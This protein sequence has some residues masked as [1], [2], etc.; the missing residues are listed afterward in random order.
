MLLGGPLSWATVSHGAMLGPHRRDHH[1]R[2]ITGGEQVTWR[3]A[4]AER[5][6]RECRVRAETRHWIDSCSEWR[7]VITIMMTMRAVLRRGSGARRAIGGKLSSAS[8][9]TKQRQFVICL[10]RVGRPGQL[11]RKEAGVKRARYRARAA[12]DVERQA[13]SFGILMGLEGDGIITLADGLVDV[14][15]SF[16]RSKRAQWRPN[17][18][19]RHGRSHDGGGGGDGGGAGRGRVGK[20][21]I[22]SRS[23]VRQDSDSDDGDGDGSGREEWAAGDSDVERVAVCNVLRIFWTDEMVWFRCD[24]TKLFDSGREVE[25]EYRVDGWAPCRHRLA[26]VQWEQWAEGG[27]VD[28]GEMAYEGEDWMG[29]IDHEAL[30]AAAGAR[31]RD[32]RRGRKDVDVGGGTEIDNLDES[33]EEWPGSG[34]VVGGTSAGDGAP[35][36]D[37]YGWIVAGVAGG[38]GSKQRKAF[39]R[40]IIKASEELGDEDGAV[41]VNVKE[42]YKRA[43]SFG[44]GTRV[45]SQELRAMARAGL[46]V[47]KHDA[48]YCGATEDSGGGV[49]RSA[50]QEQDG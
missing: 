38:R 5:T 36:G 2:L 17:I 10:A 3:Q 43:G 45:A 20:R 13:A 48:V 25:V 30:R 15:V 6:G 22:T 16:K 11:E 40:C 31:H 1:L 18:G 32:A 28:E 27:D 42:L 41:N 24:V 29:P 37:T 26:D 8:L 23:A 47:L 34:Q 4:E 9:L 14:D 50:G 12:A 44:K 21:R 49:D 19:R 33:D 35:Q 46:I 39:A 7:A